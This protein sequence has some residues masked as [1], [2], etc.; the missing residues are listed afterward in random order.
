MASCIIVIPCYNEAERL[1]T[2]KFLTYLSHSPDVS[3]LFVNDGSRDETIE[4]LRRMQDGTQQVQVLDKQQNGG[5]GEAVREGMLHALS[6]SGVHFVGFWDADL[7]TPLEAI[8]DLLE[9]LLSQIEVALV[10]GS[11]VKLLGRD[12]DRRAFRH[13]LEAV[14]LRPA[15]LWSWTCLSMTRSA[16]Q[17]FFAR[18]LT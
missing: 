15:P 16:G 5:K 10:F 3:L 2:S 1:D 6:Q 18:L 8:G 12:I 14:C 11:R 9:V 17:N 13:S 7:A 4:V